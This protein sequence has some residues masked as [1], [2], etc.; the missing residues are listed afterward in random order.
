LGGRFILTDYVDAAMA[1]ARYE[2]LDEH[3]YGGRIEGC[4]GVIAWA[5]TPEECASELRS[6]L[7]DWVL[8]GLKL[9]HTLPVLDG[10]DL[11]RKIEHET[12]ESL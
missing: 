4:P 12:V 7:E 9:G 10:I 3:Q 11:N 6:V 8:V 5:A 1:R 2:S